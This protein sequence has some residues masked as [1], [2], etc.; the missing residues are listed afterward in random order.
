M[1]YIPKWKELQSLSDEELISKYDSSANNTIVGTG[2]YREEL[3]RRAT[4]KQ[5]DEMVN[6]SRSVKNMTIAI[7]VL[8][9]FNVAL[10]GVTLL[11]N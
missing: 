10:V 7:L 3:S 2:F 6:I 5:N 4:N 11:V 1:S 8:T 9:V